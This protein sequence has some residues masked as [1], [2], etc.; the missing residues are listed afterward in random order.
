M[1]PFRFYFSA[2]STGLYLTVGNIGN[3]FSIIIFTNKEFRRQPITTY[4]I[5][6]CILNI[7]RL[8]TMPFMMFPS[9][10]LA[11]SLSCKLTFGVR[12]LQTEI[13]GWIAALSSFHRL[14]I[15]MAPFRFIFKDKLRFQLGLISTIFIFLVLFQSPFFYYYKADS[16]S[17]NQTKCT[18]PLE[19]E[20]NWILVYIKYTY[21]LL[22]TILPFSIMTVSSI[23]I[24]WR[25]YRS[26]QQLVANTDRQREIQLAKSLL[27]FDLF[28]I[29]F[30]LPMMV[31][32]LLF[33][34][35]DEDR[36]FY[37]LTYP[38]LF[39]ISNFNIVFCF[40]IFFIFNRLYHDLF[41]LYLRR[42][43]QIIFCINFQK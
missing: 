37:N 2:V 22:E 39:V 18:I 34:S 7:T 5:F 3:I 12:M 36:V 8:I 31:Y 42:I 28:F 4:L 32:L 40:V 6:I 35:S 43:K 38:I 29:V 14:I 27:A 24:A 13:Q 16:T 25:M 9:M 15:V 26:K 11:T 20:F 23:L 17:D 41:I 33:N 10:W 19:P 1:E 30:R 21:T